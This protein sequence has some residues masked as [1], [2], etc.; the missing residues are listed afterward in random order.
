MAVGVAIS[1]WPVSAHQNRKPRGPQ[2]SPG[3][4]QNQRQSKLT[5]TLSNCYPNRS[6]KRGMTTCARCDNMPPSKRCRNGI[7]RGRLVSN[8]TASNRRFYTYDHLAQVPGKTVK[9]R[10]SIVYLRVSSTAH[11]PDLANQRL[12]L[13]QFCAARGR[14]RLQSVSG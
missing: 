9:S 11:K 1:L 6:I 14:A 7:G 4:D 2:V 12:A 5:S 3:L 13:E 8:R 10:L